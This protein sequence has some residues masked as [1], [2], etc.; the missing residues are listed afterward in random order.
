MK[1]LNPDKKI[2]YILNKYGYRKDTKTS[3]VC[4]DTDYYRKGA[5]ENNDIEIVAVRRYDV[6]RKFEDSYYR[7]EIIM[8]SFDN[9]YL[10]G[11]GKAA[12]IWKG[13]YEID[14]APIGDRVDFHK[15]YFH[16]ETMGW[17]LDDKYKGVIEDVRVRLYKLKEERK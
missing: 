6:F 14:L 3:R 4:R 15:D 13:S 5:I 17:Y 1:N 8:V 2:V 10:M 11:V 9:C 12:V 16:I 7:Q